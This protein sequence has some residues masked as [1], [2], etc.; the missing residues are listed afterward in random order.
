M[1]VFFEGPSIYNVPGVI[2]RAPFICHCWSAVAIEATSFLL[3]FNTL[4]CLPLSPLTSHIIGEGIPSQKDDRPIRVS[5]FNLRYSL[6]S[7]PFPPGFPD[8]RWPGF[9]SQLAEHGS[10]SQ[11]HY[12]RKS[13]F[14]S[15][16][17]FSRSVRTGCHQNHNAR[18]I[19]WPHPIPP[20]SFC[21]VFRLHGHFY[22]FT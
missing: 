3:P 19:S 10:S 18:Q 15:P 13:C 4:Q 8:Q 7:P 20:L 22:D 21:P 11:P 14:H 12:Q 2:M 16:Q 1:R 5:T 6:L 17:H 9:K